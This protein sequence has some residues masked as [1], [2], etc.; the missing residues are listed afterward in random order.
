MNQRTKKRLKKL[1]YA[2]FSL[3]TLFQI[4]L[5]IRI[6]WL[7]SC[8]IPTYSMSPTLVG[9]D[10]ILASVQI[11]GRRIWEEDATR[12]GHYLVHRKKGTRE[13]QKKDVVVFN[14]P[15]AENKDKMILSDKVFYCKRCAATPGETYQ[16][17]MNNQWRNV[18]LPKKGDILRIDSINF[19]D[20]HRCIE[21]ETD[22]SIRMDNAG[23]VYLADTLL[24]IYRFQH[25]YYFM[26]GDNTTDSYDSR[27]WGLLPDDFILGVGQCIWFSKD[28]KTKQI[29]W[30][31][32]FKKI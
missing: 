20:Y 15:Y 19:N 28:Q 11:P 30:N 7:V 13:I 17:P 23:K 8:T 29:R 6:Y 24:N 22:A 21:Y 26:C 12:P 18:Y 31:R 25:N 9:G 27:Y 14:F 10:Y 4:Y 5:S 3:F 16:W 1:G 32:M 2:F